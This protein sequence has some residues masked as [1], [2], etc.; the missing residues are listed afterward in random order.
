[1]KIICIGR[2]YAEHVKEL[3]DGGRVTED[4]IFFMK[5]DTALLRNNDPF[6]IPDFTQ[7]LHYETELVVRISRTARSIEERFARRCYD[8]VGLGLDFTARDLQRRCIAEGLPWEI[9]KSFDR[10][11]AVS[12]RFLK[13]ADLGG[14][15]QRLQFEM[16]LNGETRQR[17]DTSQMIH[18][19]DRII[20]YVSRFVT[21]R[22]GD[23]IFTGT[24]AGVGPLK[25]GDRITAQLSGEELI[26]MVVK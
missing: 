20:A 6:Y 7:E 15:V 2:N 14:D 12:P 19:V 4:P 10:S 3:H 11:A 5:P 25:K 18:S 16:Q 13:L 9:C 8:E 26:D 24:P 17:G 23:L 1:M 22:M 21:L